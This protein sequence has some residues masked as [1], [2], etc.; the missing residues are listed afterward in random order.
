[1]L[2]GPHRA[3]VADLERLATGKGAGEIG[4]DAVFRPVAAADHIAG[5]R[6]PPGGCRQK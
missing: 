1:M 4:Q 5:A 2:P 3:G 6:R